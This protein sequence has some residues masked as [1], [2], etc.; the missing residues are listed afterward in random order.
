[1]EI[2]RVFSRSETANLPLVLVSW[3]AGWSLFII[4]ERDFIAFTKKAGLCFNFLADNLFGIRW[5]WYENVHSFGL[6]VDLVETKYSLQFSFISCS[7]LAQLSLILLRRLFLGI[8]DTL[9]FL[10]DVLS[11]GTRILSWLIQQVT[12]H[13]LNL[14]R[15]HEMIPTGVVHRPPNAFC[16][17]N[18]NR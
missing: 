9:R 5:F 16:N 7:F 17:R 18:N 15:L 14:P 4:V 1:M 13:F 8:T 11:T 2:L 12:Y 3:G 6:L 10:T